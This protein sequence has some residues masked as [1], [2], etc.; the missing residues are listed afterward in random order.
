MVSIKLLQAELDSLLS[1]DKIRE[2]LIQTWSIDQFLNQS[3]WT[4]TVNEIQFEL[5]PDF[6]ITVVKRILYST[7]C[8]KSLRVRV[9]AAIGGIVDESEG[10]R[11][12]FYEAIYFFVELNYNEDLEVFSTYE[13]ININ[14][15]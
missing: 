8:S 3:N 12:G 9:I 1:E 2:D 14:R 15:L 6:A 4:C 10:L 7:D 13:D 5:P 11:T